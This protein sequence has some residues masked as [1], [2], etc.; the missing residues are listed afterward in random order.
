MVAESSRRSLWALIRI[1]S[2]LLDRIEQSDYR[3]FEKRISLSALEKAGI[4]IRS[5]T[6]A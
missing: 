4:V 6:V 1:Y 2:S 3:V 5:L